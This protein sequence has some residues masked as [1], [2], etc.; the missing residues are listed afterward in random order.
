MFLCEYLILF[1]Q[2]N[3]V[4]KWRIWWYSITFSFHMVGSLVT[5]TASV[6]FQLLSVVFRADFLGWEP[7]CSLE[8]WVCTVAMESCWHW[9]LWRNGQCYVPGSRYLSLTSH[10]LKPHYTRGIKML[11]FF[12]KKILLLSYIYS[13]GKHDFKFQI[14]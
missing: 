14:S 10:F 1:D 2:M 13:C 12:L 9:W 5:N 6:E 7:Y 11:V 8:K 4:R 3:Y